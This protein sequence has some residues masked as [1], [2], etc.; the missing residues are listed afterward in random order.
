MDSRMGIPA[1]HFF[2]A[3]L[4]CYIPGIVYPLVHPV[5]DSVEKSLALFRFPLIIYQQR[6]PACVWGT[7]ANS[8]TKSQMLH[9]V[10]A[11]F[12]I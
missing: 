6:N 10:L 11:R 7:A 2:P 4:S 12:L 5:P 1:N 3:Y 9:P 8:N